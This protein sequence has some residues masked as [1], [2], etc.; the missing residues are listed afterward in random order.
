MFVGRHKDVKREVSAMFHALTSANGRFNTGEILD[1]KVE[2]LDVYDT[3]GSGMSVTD[4]LGSKNRKATSIDK[5][6]VSI[7]NHW[8][9]GPSRAEK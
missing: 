3:I 7:R 9:L 1:V 6:R 5:I 2:G 8:G 4:R